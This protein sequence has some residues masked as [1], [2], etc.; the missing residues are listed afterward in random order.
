MRHGPLQTFI[1]T[2]GLARRLALIALG[3]LATENTFLGQLLQERLH[4][5]GASH[6]AIDRHDQHPTRSDLR[7][8]AVSTRVQN[9]KLDP[10]DAVQHVDARESV[11]ELKIV[12][13]WLLTCWL[14]S[15]GTAR[16]L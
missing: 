14:G 3:R 5:R 16:P 13:H 6:E 11:N 8:L 15:C 9:A 7:L 4:G 2:A 1:S 12:W 10:N